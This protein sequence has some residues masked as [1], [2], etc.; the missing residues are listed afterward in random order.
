MLARPPLD[1]WGRRQKK[2]GNIWSGWR[3]TSAP[4]PKQLFVQKIQFT[5]DLILLLHILV[6]SGLVWRHWSFCGN[7]SCE[8]S[9][10]ILGWFIR[11][12]MWFRLFYG[13]TD[14]Q[15]NG[16]ECDIRMDFD[17]N[18]YP[19]IF[20][21]KKWHK[22]ISEYIHMKFFDPNEYTNIFV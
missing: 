11:L 1:L 15:T 17:T 9:D 19:N 8:G 20:V 13:W 4:S 22:R 12:Y 3:S 14:G 6:W 10:M 2:T 21:S 18:K 5:F 16:P 7:I